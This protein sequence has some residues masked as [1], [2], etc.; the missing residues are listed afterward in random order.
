MTQPTTLVVPT[1]GRPSLAVLM[2]AL[3][4][5]TEPVRSP[6]VLVDDR[7]SE[8]N[9]Q[10]HTV[11]HPDLDVRLLRTGGRGPAAARNRG[12]R[13][14]RTP[15]VSFLDDDVVP[16]P[17]WYAALL[18]DLV[19]ADEQGATGSQGRVHVPLP[20]DRR[21]TDWERGTHGLET[22]R[23][24]TADMSFR[25]R[26]LVAV[27]GFDER[28]PRAFREDADLALRLG[29]EH[30]S[31]LDG[32]RRITHPVRPAD[33]WASVRQQAGNADDELMR[34]LHG[35]DWHVRAG[36]PVGRWTRH[37][38]ISAA[39]SVALAATAAR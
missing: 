11:D 32:R 12:W 22:A 39:G 38:A 16:D 20:T 5:Q 13:H 19:D 9:G 17:D 25:R 14:A 30:G 1:L 10:L 3:A 33:D 15:W 37:A 35:P 28:F 18:E 8:T 2:R 6:I 21:P 27:G 34:V 29:A 31:V 36:A 7:P 23:W 24:I 4:Q 26:G